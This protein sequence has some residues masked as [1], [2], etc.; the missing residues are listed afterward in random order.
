M[1]NINFQKEVLDKSNT[2]PVVVDFWAPWCGPCQFLGPVLEELV[3]EEKGKWELVKVNVDE[4]QEISAQFGIRGIPDVRMFYKEKSIA[5]FTG[6]LPKHQIQRWLDE[7]LPDERNGT[8]EQIKTLLLVDS[9]KGFQQLKDL[10]ASNPDFEEGK[11]TLANRIV[12][13]HPKQAEDLIALFKIGHKLFNQAEDIRQLARLMQLGNNG[14]SQVPESVLLAQEALKK[15]L[16]DTAL[17]QLI[18]AVM[19]DKDYED[20]LPRKATVALFHLLGD[21]HEVT[22]KYRKR[23]D[24]ALY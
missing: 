11:L 19:T 5:N 6:A 13:N 1:A 12:F 9:K 4:N 21:Q 2:H 10:V 15:D 3:E 7:Y 8:L 24:M 14:Q 18:S 20:E 16:Y 23:F 22:K 17:Q